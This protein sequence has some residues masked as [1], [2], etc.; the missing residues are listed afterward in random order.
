V[1]SAQ[2]ADQ[3]KPARTAKIRPPAL[4][5]LAVITL[6]PTIL[7]HSALYPWWDACFA[8]HQ[9]PVGNVKPATILTPEITNA[10]YALTVCRGV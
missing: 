7:A 4:A 3:F 8:H 5:A 9:L 2:V 6:I 1:E 10:S